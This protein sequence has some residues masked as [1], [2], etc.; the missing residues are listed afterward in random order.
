MVPPC[1]HTAAPCLSLPCQGGFSCI[2]RT[3]ALH[4]SLHGRPRGFLCPAEHLAAFGYAARN[5]AGAFPRLPLAVAALGLNPSLSLRPRRSVVILRAWAPRGPA[6]VPAGLVV[7]ERI[8]IRAPGAA[9]P[10]CVGLTTEPCPWDCLLHSARSRLQNVLGK[11]NA[12][13]SAPHVIFSSVLCPPGAAPDAPGRTTLSSARRAAGGQPSRGARVS[14]HV[15]LQPVAPVRL[16]FLLV[17]VLPSPLLLNKRI[18]AARRVAAGEIIGHSSRN[19]CF[20][21]QEGGLQLPGAGLQQLDPKGGWWCAPWRGKAANTFS[22][23]PKHSI[24]TP[25][26]PH[27]DKSTCTPQLHTPGGSSQSTRRGLVVLPGGEGKL[28]GQ[29][30]PGAVTTA[31]QLEGI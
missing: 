18:A 28:C 23:R 17:V 14:V 11:E 6:A 15:S 16:L 7:T 3:R 26:H 25:T 27:P 31:T 20:W 29:P 19:P 22:A 13:S 5:T 1:R 8:C 21:G 2:Q 10:R 12:A 9:H 24:L 30:N 4:A